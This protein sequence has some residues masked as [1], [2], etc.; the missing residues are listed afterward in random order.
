MDINKCMD[1]GASLRLVSQ[2]SY[3]DKVLNCTR[4]NNV[5]REY[6]TT[7]FTVYNSVYQATQSK[8]ASPKSA[9][10]TS[11]KLKRCRK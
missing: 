6:R 8:T 5:V 9:S 2:N 11:D 4:C 7:N 10:Q 3:G 1:C